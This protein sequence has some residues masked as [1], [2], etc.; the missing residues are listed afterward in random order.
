MKTEI[1]KQEQQKEFKPFELKIKVETA[2]EAR[3]L[4]HI[5]NHVNVLK[6]IKT[7]RFWDTGYIKSHNQ[8]IAK[9]LD[10]DIH[11]II[12]NELMDQ[13]IEL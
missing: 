10:C 2:A 5:G 9:D 6:T 12:Q 11:V 8:D 3:L 13:D 4:Y 7:A 1:I